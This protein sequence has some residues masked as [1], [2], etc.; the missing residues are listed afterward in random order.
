MSY[1]QNSF[2]WLLEIT[3][4]FQRSNHSSSPLPSC[5]R[6][7]SFLAPQLCS[8]SIFP[9][10]GFSEIWPSTIFSRD[11]TI[12]GVELVTFRN[13]LENLATTNINWNIGASFKWTDHWPCAVEK[14]LFAVV[15]LSFADVCRSLLSLFA[16]NTHS[17]TLV[18]R[19]RA[20]QRE[21]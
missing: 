1:I 12:D 8:P 9:S 7:S 4:F 15:K 17:W 16:L 21:R 11:T 14:A 13:N 2:C 6:C 18:T 10:T 20:P 5:S 3:S 19:D